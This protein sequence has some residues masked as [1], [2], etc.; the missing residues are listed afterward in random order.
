MR[1][2]WAFL[3]YQ[4]LQKFETILKKLDWAPSSISFD[5]DIWESHHGPTYRNM[6]FVGVHVHATKTNIHCSVLNSSSEPSKG[7]LIEYFRRDA[8]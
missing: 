4:N 1:K 7:V 8:N 5:N 3:W 2:I 6:S